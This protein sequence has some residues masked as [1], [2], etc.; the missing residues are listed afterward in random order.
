[1]GPS[2]NFDGP[3]SG[4][5]REF[6]VSNA[7]YWIDEFHFDGLRIDAA[8]QMFD[9]SGRHIL[10]EIGERARAAAGGR[11]V[12][13]VAENEPQQ[14]RMVRPEAEGGYGLDVTWNE[15][16]H[17]SAVVAVTGRAE[18]YYSD[19]RGRPQELISAAK[20]GFLFQGQFY[21]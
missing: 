1:M 4:P 20:Y 21:V 9:A 7:G 13:L 5:V 15:D 3:A 19:H 17:N 18:A 8:Q 11:G 2:V 12:L 6:F 10:A 14:A 16:F